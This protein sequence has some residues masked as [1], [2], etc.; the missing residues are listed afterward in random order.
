MAFTLPPLPYSYDGLAPYISSDTLHF[1][2]D[3]H[4]AGYFAK[5]NGFVEGTP[6]ATKSLEEVVRT[7]TGAIFNNAAQAW[8]HT[9]YFQSMK[10]PSLG[11]G[12]EPTGRLRDEINKQ[13]SN[14]DNF[15]DEFSKLAAGHFGSGWAWLTWDKN[16]KRV[17]IEQTHDA[18]T[19]LTEPAKVP[20]LCCDVWE[21]AYYL[22]RKNDR[23]AYIK[24]CKMFIL[25]RGGKLS[26]GNSRART[27]R[28]HA[29]ERNPNQAAA[30]VRDEGA[31][32]NRCRPLPKLRNVV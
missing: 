2:H 30:A 8:N 11:G 21:H 25:Q 19:P 26:T 31:T 22:D 18:G 32:Q 9:F 3:K 4:H 7:S 17:G 1:H 29:N 23:P 6:F 24:G 10:P 27:S 15:R 28:R 13:F 16:S 5:L 12:G 14:Y 20:L